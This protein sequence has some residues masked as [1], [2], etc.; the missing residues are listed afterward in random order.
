MRMR[1]AQEVFFGESFGWWIACSL[2]RTSSCALCISFPAVFCCLKSRKFATQTT[3]PMQ[4]SPASFSYQFLA[5]PHPNASPHFHFIAF[6]HSAFVRACFFVASGAIELHHYYHCWNCVFYS[7][8]S[9]P[10]FSLL[11]IQSDG[12]RSY[13]HWP[14]FVDCLV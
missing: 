8:F 14:P 12:C 3:S 13:R 4:S 6:S 1:N 2:Q 7:F 5:M 11:N 10:L 9:L